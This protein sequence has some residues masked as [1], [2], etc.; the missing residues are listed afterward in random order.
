M[1][2]VYR[3]IGWK[4]PIQMMD[5]NY[6]NKATRGDGI[7]VITLKKWVRKYTKALKHCGYY[8]YQMFLFVKKD[9]V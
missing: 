3:I 1:H 8:I 6:C 4:L 9:V 2:T 7:L 5:K